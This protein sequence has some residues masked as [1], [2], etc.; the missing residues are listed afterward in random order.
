MQYKTASE[1]SIKD[2]ELL[3]SLDQSNWTPYEYKV[4][5]QHATGDWEILAKGINLW[6]AQGR[7]QLVSDPSQTWRVALK[8]YELGEN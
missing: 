8:L 6:I 4:L 7:P 5:R 2:D 1:L 3:N